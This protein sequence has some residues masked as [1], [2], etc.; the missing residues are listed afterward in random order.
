MLRCE[1]ADMASG[2]TIEVVMK[3]DSR[4]GISMRAS[5]LN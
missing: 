3:R 1:K 2:N 5:F 4:E